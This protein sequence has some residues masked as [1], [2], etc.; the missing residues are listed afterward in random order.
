MYG[1]RASQGNGCKIS[2]KTLAR[3]TS[4]WHAKELLS[5]HID[6]DSLFALLT[7]IRNGK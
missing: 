3:G 7:L 5:H 6:S 2:E 4:T 1:C